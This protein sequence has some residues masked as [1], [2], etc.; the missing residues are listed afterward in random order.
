MQLALRMTTAKGDLEKEKG[1][2]GNEVITKQHLKI[3]FP[4][5]RLEINRAE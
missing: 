3:N 5:L 4:E 2:D 1:I